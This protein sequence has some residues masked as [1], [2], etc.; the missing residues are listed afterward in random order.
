VVIENGWGGDGLLTVLCTL[1]GKIGRYP[2][3]SCKKGSIV[4]LDWSKDQDRVGKKCIGE[5]SSVILKNSAEMV[6]P[7]WQK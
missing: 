1:T 4:L 5:H 3:N 7:H 2:H 6:R